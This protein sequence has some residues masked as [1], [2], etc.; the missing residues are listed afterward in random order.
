MYSRFL[1]YIHEEKLFE[2]S[3]KL[4]LGVSGGIDS[5]ALANL[6]DQL[7]NEFA[8]AHCNFNLRGQDSDDDE[9]FVV[10]LADQFGVKCFLSSFATREYATE[11][12]ISIE[13]AA[14]ELRYNW[15]ET[16][17]TENGF[18]WI[19]VAH[20]LDD[21]LETFVLNLSRGTG[22]RGLSGI[23]PKAGKVV[24][25][26]LFASRVEI[27]EYANS[28]ELNFRHDASNDDIQIKRNKVRHQILPLMETLNPSF[29]KNLERTITYLNETKE[30]YL[31]KIELVRQE[32]VQSENDWTKISIDKLKQLEPLSAY[33]FELLRPF[34][35]NSDV[36][37]EIGRALYSSPG[38]RF[39][40]STHRL[41]VDREEL[42]ITTIESKAK[43][44]FYI[45]KNVQFIR[46][47]VLLR[48]KIERYHTEYNIPRTADVAV[49]DYDKLRFPL[50]LRRWH[51]G[52]YFKPFGMKGF[53]KLSDFFVDEKY[54]IPE[55]ENI[56]LL[57][58]DNKV[59]WIVG[60]RIDDRFKLTRESKLVLRIELITSENA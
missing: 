17:R 48:L 58:S 51:Q 42:I 23:K 57:A 2:R 13:M 38:L 49:F 59:V 32:L 1:K 54:S 24:R 20:H 43:E 9:N 60:K 53:K 19:L 15:F 47:P 12:R 37:E 40:S 18:D 10:N 3:E 36:V 7:G 14:R 56:W 8:I 52:E 44:V 30:V 22:I 11:N 4:L 31:S 34:H 26:L 5:V 46:D 50:V 21:V 29:R 6:V 35:F 33:L 16:I 45:D 39:F 41:V 55:K 28:K 27:E 25:P